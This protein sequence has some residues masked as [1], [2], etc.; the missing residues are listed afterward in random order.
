MGTTRLEHTSFH[1]QS[2]PS[3]HDELRVEQVSVGKYRV[4]E[5]Y[6]KGMHE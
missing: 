4:I 5:K 2:F 3:V 1:L 6:G